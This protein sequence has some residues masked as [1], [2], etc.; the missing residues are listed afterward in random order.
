MPF[1][2]ITN[3]WKRA[4]CFSLLILLVALSNVFP[5]IYAGIHNHQITYKG[6]LL[7]FGFMAYA[8]ELGFAF[9]DEMNGGNDPISIFS[10]V[11]DLFWLGMLTCT[12]VLGLATGIVATVAWGW[13]HGFGI[14][15]VV[16]IST[17]FVA[18]IFE[19]AM[20]RSAQKMQS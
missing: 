14:G 18:R 16:S 20:R 7:L 2:Y 1:L 6:T 3:T 4:V 11:L 8:F 9:H 13:R 17:Y 5:S 10:N 15:L 19:W 12:A